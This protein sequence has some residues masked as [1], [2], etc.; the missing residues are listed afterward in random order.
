MKICPFCKGAQNLFVIGD[1]KPEWIDCPSCLHL[2]VRH[3]KN[4]HN[5]KPDTEREKHYR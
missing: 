5:T 1:G 2:G 3:E 4:K